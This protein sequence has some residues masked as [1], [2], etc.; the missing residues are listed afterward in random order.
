M[1][2]LRADW[3]WKM[4]DTIWYRILCLPSDWTCT[5]WKCVDKNLNDNGTLEEQMLPT[6]AQCD[7]CADA[8][9]P[10]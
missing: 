4:P 7:T 10:K 9:C 3:I 6:C 5:V 1:K 8:Q 2:N